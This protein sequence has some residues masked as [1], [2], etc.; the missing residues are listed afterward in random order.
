M[1]IPTSQMRKQRYREVRRELGC[2]AGRPY[3]RGTILTTMLCDFFKNLHL[4]GKGV[5]LG[6]YIC[7]E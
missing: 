4:K 7:K 1:I 6:F 3:S 5:S 2:S